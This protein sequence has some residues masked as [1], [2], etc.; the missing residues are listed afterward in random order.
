MQIPGSKVNEVN[1]LLPFSTGALRPPHVKQ[2][3]PAFP[4]FLLLEDRV[5][6]GQ[7]ADGMVLRGRP[8]TDEE[9]GKALGLHPKTVATHRQRLER[10]GYIQTK[11]TG[12]GH[13]ISVRKSKKWFWMQAGRKSDS[14]PSD[15]AKRLH[16]KEPIGSVRGSRTAPSR[17]DKLRTNQRRIKDWMPADKQQADP[18]FQLIADHYRRRTQERTGITPPWDAADGKSLNRILADQRQVPAE[19]IIKWLDAA[20]DGADQYPLQ[21]GFRFTQFAKHYP[22]YAARSRPGNEWTAP[23]GPTPPSLQPEPVRPKTPW[24]GNGQDPY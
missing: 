5:T 14:V 16:Q 17:S 3:G 13:I 8:V 20:F 7:G 15:G 1:Y 12:R 22:T 11:R 4:L 19:E 23:G 21:D 9:L 18:R 2:I 6:M 10:Y 24:K